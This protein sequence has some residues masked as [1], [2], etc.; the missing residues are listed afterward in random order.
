MHCN[1]SF[2]SQ[3][4]EVL[5][6]ISAWGIVHFTSLV[7]QS[8]LCL[9]WSNSS[10][11]NSLPYTAAWKAGFETKT[12]LSAVSSVKDFSLTKVFEKSRT[13]RELYTVSFHTLENQISCRIV[14]LKA[15]CQ[16]QHQKQHKNNYCAASSGVIL[17]LWFCCCG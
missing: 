7:F 14:G 15:H 12:T 2:A 9:T 5:V 17:W 10:G 1:N 4:I 16:Q 11:S 6:P 13:K 3:E 8:Q